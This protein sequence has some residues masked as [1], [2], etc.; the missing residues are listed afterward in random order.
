MLRTSREFRPNSCFGARGTLLAAAVLAFGLALG[1]APLQAG[2]DMGGGYG[3]GGYGGGGY[4]G[5]GWGGHGGYGHGGHGRYGGV[6]RWQGCNSYRLAAFAAQR[7]DW[8]SQ[9]ANLDHYNDC[10]RRRWID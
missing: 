2:G 7:G 5:G 6:A 10:M 8:R 3:G 4:G 9:N 1:A